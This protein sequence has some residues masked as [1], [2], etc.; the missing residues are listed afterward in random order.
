MSPELTF[1]IDTNALP[2]LPRTAPFP[3]Q[4]DLRW[5][6]STRALVAEDDVY[7]SLAQLQDEEGRSYGDGIAYIEHT[8]SEPKHGRNLYVWMR[9]GDVLDRDDLLFAVFRFAAEKMTPRP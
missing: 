4:G 5:R 9:M 1:H 3:Q 6:P 2:G 8:A 7:L